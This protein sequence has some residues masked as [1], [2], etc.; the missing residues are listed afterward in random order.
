MGNVAEAAMGD[1]AEPKSLWATWLEEV[2]MGNVA[3]VAIGDLGWTEV[4]MG[5]LA[6]RSCYGQLGC[7]GSMS[8]PKSLWATWLEE[9]AMG[10]LAAR[11]ASLGQCEWA[12]AKAEVARAA[13]PIGW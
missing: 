6:R 2:A 7:H 13:R 5:D 3:E 10:N 1:L 8:R 11:A 9:V 4:A 12:E